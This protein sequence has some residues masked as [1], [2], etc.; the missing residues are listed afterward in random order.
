MDTLQIDQCEICVVGAGIAGLNALSAASQYLGRNDRVVLVDRRTRVGGM[1]TDTYDYVRLHQPYQLFTAG[2]IKWTLGKDRCYLATKPEIL[3]HLR[4][5][6]NVL[7]R[8]VDIDERLGWD[9]VSHEE[10]GGLVSVTL[11]APDGQTRVITAR[12]LIKAFG[13]EMKPNPP[14]AVSSTRVQSATPNDMHRIVDS[15]TP[16]W[17]IGGG[18]TGLDTAHTLITQCPGREVN[19]LVGSGSMALRRD[20]LFSTGASRWFGG[21]PFTTLSTEFAK[22]YDGTNEDEVRRWLYSA[23]GTGPTG[24]RCEFAHGIGGCTSDVEMAVID[25][26][27]RRADNEYLADVVDRD[28]HAELVY[29]SGQTTRVAEGTWIVNCTGLQLRGSH[30]YEPFV[31][32][33]GQTLSIQHR[34]AV[35]P[36]T[37]Q[38]GYFLT[39]LMFTGGLSTLPLYELDLEDLRDKLGK[40]PI[41]AVFPLTAYNLSLAFDHLPTKVFTGFGSDLLLW[42]PLPRRLAAF[43][44][45]QVNHRRERQTNRKTLDTIRQRCGV[46]CGPLDHLSRQMRRSML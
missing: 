40:S 5:C 34:S 39:H 13:S 9:Y 8:R 28:G 45:F 31:S 22:R 33:S 20:V 43:A 11:R 27:L 42:Y 10:S 6:L 41:P 17:I 38:A 2:N 19:M 36:I 37:L 23:V 12:R 15:N 24:E 14:L 46:R 3:D 25:T 16:V 21:L 1:W 44:R 26:G 30:P 7:S 32:P 35:I 29:R 18:K 4:H